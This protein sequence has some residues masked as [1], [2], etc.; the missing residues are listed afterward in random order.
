MRHVLTV[1][2]DSNRLP[3]ELTSKTK[4]GKKFPKSGEGMQAWL[5]SSP[6]TEPH[7]LLLM[8][9][10]RQH[11]NGKLGWR[12]Q[13]RVVRQLSRS[14]PER[15]VSGVDQ[16]HS[17]VSTLVG[18]DACKFA[19]NSAWMQHPRSCN[20]FKRAIS[21]S[22]RPCFDPVQLESR[23]QS[24]PDRRC[25]TAVAWREADRDRSRLSFFSWSKWMNE[26]TT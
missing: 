17:V 18:T 23:C 11:K 26:S 19:E 4:S 20:A 12:T 14:D 3:M 1:C 24:R 21:N 10:A 5:G 22:R 16:R 9:A 15:S 13:S 2:N 8:Q 7:I 6:S 25:V